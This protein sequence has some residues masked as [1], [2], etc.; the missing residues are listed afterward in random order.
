MP[1]TLIFVDLPTPEPDATARFYRE[2]FGWVVEGRP[3]GVFYRCVPGGYFPN[4]DGS[5]SEVG[6]LHL[7]IFATDLAPPDPA[8]PPAQGTGPIGGPAPRVY[9][10]VGDEDS[11][12][13]I[14]ARAEEHGATV[15]WRN[16]YWKEFNGFHA[17]FRDPWGTEIILWSKGGDAPTPTQEQKA[18][19]ADKG[20]PEDAQ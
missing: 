13:A 17:A 9:I 3:D 5:D 19:H 6:N 20:Y 1:N 7:G 4:D 14:L 15:L 8:T 10:L 18:W 11:E 16:L 12:D 2:V